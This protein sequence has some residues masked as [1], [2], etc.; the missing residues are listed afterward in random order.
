MFG[1]FAKLGRAQAAGTSPIWQNFLSQP[2]P[3]NAGGVDF[4]IMETINYNIRD[5]LGV[6]KDEFQGLW[7]DIE[8]LNQKLTC[9]VLYRH[10]RVNLEAFTNYLYSCLDKIQQE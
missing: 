9:G 10:P 7:V 8:I 6:S 1:N 5:D 4:Y 3:T 2:T